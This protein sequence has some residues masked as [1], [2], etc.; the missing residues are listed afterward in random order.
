MR[1]QHVVAAKL[2]M[3]CSLLGLLFMSLVFGLATGCGKPKD[4]AVAQEISETANIWNEVTQVLSKVADKQSGEDA[5]PKMLELA[6]R[7]KKVMDDKKKKAE[8]AEKFGKHP[9]TLSG[10]QTKMAADA[11]AKFNKE[12]ERVRALEGGQQLMNDFWSAMNSPPK[13]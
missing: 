8:E 11:T 7:M 12:Q 6:G 2:G 3:L 4:S 13:E 1:K 10:A 9:P 5:K